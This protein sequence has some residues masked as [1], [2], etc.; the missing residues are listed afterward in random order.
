MCVSAEVSFTVAGLLIAGGS[1]CLYKADKVDKSYIPL[2]LFPLIVGIQQIAEGLVWRGFSLD[3]PATVQAAALAYLFFTWIFWPFWVPYMTARLEL[4]KNR[5]F[6]FK[7]CSMAG[8]AFGLLLYLPNYF[9]DA[10][11]TV[12]TNNH[13]IAYDCRFMTESIAPRWF[14]YIIYLSLIGLP[15][16]F[17]SHF[18][19][20]I[21]GA[22]LITAVPLTYVAFAYAHVS[23]LCFFAAL[24][25]IYLVYLISADKCAVRQHRQIPHHP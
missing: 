4:Q 22:A 16:L 11:L 6:I 20:K 2:A 14:H 10:L 25:T 21:F 24:I 23:V 9:D 5:A 13:S 19:L 15:P 18:Y 7:L 12:T 8:L 17:S 1:Y 3:D